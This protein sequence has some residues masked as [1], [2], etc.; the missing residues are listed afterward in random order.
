MNST[1]M[2]EQH[3]LW[4]FPRIPQRGLFMTALLLVDEPVLEFK[5]TTTSKVRTC[6]HVAGCVA[7]WK[8]SL[9]AMLGITHVAVKQ[10]GTPQTLP[11]MSLTLKSCTYSA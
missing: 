9:Y 2:P 10:R 8:I 6:V 7:S 3:S 1:I 4:R 5:V 11:L